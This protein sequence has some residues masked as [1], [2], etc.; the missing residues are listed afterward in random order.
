MRNQINAI[1]ARLVEA[2]R[3]LSA[4]NEARLK[5]AI[6]SLS[7]VLSQLASE[8]A[9]VAA[10]EAER[11]F[12]ARRQLIQ[13]A[14]K[15]RQV[16]GQ[17]YSSYCYVMDVFDTDFV[18]SQGDRLYRAA[19]LMDEAG[20]VA[21]GAAVEVLAQVIYTPAPAPGTMPAM[22][23][24]EAAPLV[25]GE[26]QPLVESAESLQPLALNEAATV[27]LKLIGP[28]W[29]TSGYYSADVLKKAAGVF[30]AG[31]K[32]FW[33]HPTKAEEAARPEGDLDRMAA[34]LKENARWEDNGPSGPGLY[35]KAKAYDKYVKPLKE[36][37]K[38]IGVSI[39]A[40]GK[41]RTG[42]AEGREGVIVESIAG[43]KS[44]D[45]V[46]TPGRGGEILNLFE[47][48]ARGPAAAIPT[49]E[50][51][52][53]QAEVQALIEAAVGPLNTRVTAAEAKATNLE[54]E[55]ARLRERLALGE[56][57][58]FV[59]ARLKAIPNLPAVTRDRLVGQLV[60]QATLTEAGALDTAALGALVESAAQAEVQYLASVTGGARV[61]GMG[62]SLPAKAAAPAADVEASQKRFE[63]SFRD[64]AGLS[65]TGLKVA[66]AGRR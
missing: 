8:A 22:P 7:S 13:R 2:G 28:G 42:S 11:S 51:D 48:A 63:E 14:L 15:A 62:P 16:A 1:Y 58:P 18:Y 47:A 57:R 60:G 27:D 55:N 32:M 26:F 66:V 46:T 45:F 21:I 36:M 64:I 9:D 23:A 4:K 31:L 3:V 19:Y 41:G 59:E 39:R 25:L 65:E 29:G 5:A 61:F 38:D 44:T 6:E 20:A 30:K 50:S 43:A 49:Q 17:E 10:T 53:N 37:A 52:M 34:V 35:A 24:A 56:A 33:N 12:D 54:T 40:F